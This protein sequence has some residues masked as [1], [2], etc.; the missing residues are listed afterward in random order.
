MRDDALDEIKWR[1]NEA[2]GEPIALK[3]EKV[4]IVVKSASWSE[5]QQVIIK[6]PDPLPMTVLSLIPE[7]EG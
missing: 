6:Q 2:Y 3:T 5:T 4:K 7:I 1:S